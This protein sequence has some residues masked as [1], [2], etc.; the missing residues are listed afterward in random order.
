MIK[1]TKA[2]VKIVFFRFGII[3]FF[4][5]FFVFV[6]F[7]LWFKWVFCPYLELHREHLY[8]M[9]AL[10][11]SCCIANGL[12]KRRTLKRKYTLSSTHTSG[13]MIFQ[14]LLR[15]ICIKSVEGRL[16]LD[17]CRHFISNT[18]RSLSFPFISFPA[19]CSPLFVVCSN[20]HNTHTHSHAH[21]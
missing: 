3:A 6:I 18:D 11:I 9:R 17:R 4:C 13:H 5:F 14:G 1:K 10:L 15:R 12:K 2:D 21:Y 16:H 7:F 19:L 20:T 8:E